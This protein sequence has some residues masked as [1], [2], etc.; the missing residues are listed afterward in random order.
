MKI[1]VAAKYQL[2]HELME[3]CDRLTEAGHEVTSRWITEGGEEGKKAEEAALMDLADVVRADAVL[4]VGMPR[5]SENRGGGRWFEL[6]Y[7]YALGKRCYVVLDTTPSAPHDI[8]DEGHETVFTHLSDMT[9]L[10]SREAAV[11]HL[12]YLP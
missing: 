4:F 7:A 12:S 1:Y 11:E 5:G 2:R 3:L 6:G 9:L 10:H 8:N